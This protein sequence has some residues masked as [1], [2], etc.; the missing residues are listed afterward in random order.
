[1]DTERE[2]ERL[3]E[4]LEA[5][6]LQ[7]IEAEKR[8]ERA[9]AHFGEFV[10]TAA[11]NLREPLREVASYSQLLIEAYA[12]RFDPEADLFLR[13]IQDG[14]GRMQSLLTDVVDYWET[15]SGD[16]QPSRTD[17]D[18]VL[19]QALLCTDRQRREA[20][21]IITQDPLPP[22]SGDFELLARVLQHLIGNAIKFCGTPPARIHVSARREDLG[23]RFSVA[24]NGPGI[25]P[26]FHE[27]VFGEFN[28]LHG[29]DY[30]GNGLGL[31]F[32]KRAIEQ[33]G[34]RIWIQSRPGEGSTFYFTL[35]PAD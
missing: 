17:M 35:P 24:D 31:A 26:A 13:R 11:H 8:L 32:C 29:R 23:L 18:A 4:A 22:V 27:R 1:M 6:T 10:S 16:R 19:R 25:D 15:D 33:H 2:I 28:R 14:A 12:G 21:A 9:N 20:A 34:G 7:R 30:P 5:E 3:R